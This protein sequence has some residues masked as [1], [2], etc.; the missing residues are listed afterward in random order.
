MLEGSTATRER[1]RRIGTRYSVKTLST[2]KNDRRRYLGLSTRDIYTFV[3][4][5]I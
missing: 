4:M 1:Q 5:S 2:K 3:P